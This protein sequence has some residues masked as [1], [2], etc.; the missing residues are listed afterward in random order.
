MWLENAE[1]NTYEREKKKSRMTS[2]LASLKILVFHQ[3]RLTK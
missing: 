3:N 1:E 2:S